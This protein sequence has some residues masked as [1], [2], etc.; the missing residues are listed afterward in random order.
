[1]FGTPLGGSGAPT[2]L[3]YVPSGPTDPL[4][5]YGDA[6][7]ATALDSFIKG[8]ELA[9]YRGQI[10]PKNIARSRAFTRIDLHLEQELPTFVGTSRVSLFADINNLP[11]LIN[12]NWGGLRQLGFPPA[13]ALVNVQCVTSAGAVVPTGTRL[14]GPPPIR[15]TA[16]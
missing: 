8:T 14:S 13:A 5:Q 10:A 2:Q 15:P 11:N 12:K 9:R 3:I 6:T 4:V 7:T 16:A 1:M